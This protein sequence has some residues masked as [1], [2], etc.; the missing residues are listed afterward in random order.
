[1]IPSSFVFLD[2]LPVTANG[3]VDRGALAARHASAAPHYVPPSNDAER[4]LQELWEQ[5]LNVRP[6]SVAA[7]FDDLGGHSLL[8]A[9]LVARIESDL[10]H[11]I[12]LE[13]LFTAPT[14]REQA[15][16]IQRKL[17]LD[18]GTL[19]PFNEDGDR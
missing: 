10:G 2:S 11:K 6:V 13:T 4:S 18:G 1:M 16:V 14:V 9:Q 12:P 3:K 5:V 19:V 15:G 8:A 17:E 7:R